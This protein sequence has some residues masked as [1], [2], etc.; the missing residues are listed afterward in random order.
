MG[1]DMRNVIINGRFLLH[2]VT[3]VERYAREILA[4]LDQLIKPGEL[5][6]AI[7]P[8]TEV[9]P[10][11]KNIRVVKTG[12]LH[13]RLW[14]HI[15]F[16]AYVRKQKGISLN[17]CNVAPLSSPGI[18][19]IHDVKIKACPQYFSRKFLLWYNLLF[20]NEIKRAKKIITVSE[21]SKKEICKYYNVNPD[22]IMVIPDAWQH[23]ERI[24]FD[25]KA[26]EKYGLLKGS[27]FFSMCSLEPNKNFRW[28]AE[29]ARGNPGFNFAVAGSINRTVFAEGLGFE[30]PDNMKLL[31]Y[32]SDEEAKTLMRDCRAFLFPTIYEGFGIPPLEALSAGTK[33]IVVSDTEVMHEIFEET[34]VYINPHKY[35]LDIDK[36]TTVTEEQKE[37]ILSKYN[38]RKSAE[39]LKLLLKKQ[40]G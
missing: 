22:R 15:S 7:P 32:V 11:Y 26:L 3:G 8:E 18:V 13:N 34:V 29:A 33:N 37:R 1:K 39:L 24:G 21:F 23:Y 2:R 4:E 10:D 17:L 35:D 28:I 36:L 16:P 19:C 6:I 20:L 27:Y 30:C 31:G 9:L 12:R 5:T 25:E 40:L 38:W 14:E